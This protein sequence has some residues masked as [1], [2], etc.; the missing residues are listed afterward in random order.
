MIGISVRGAAAGRVFPEG[1]RLVGLSL[2]LPNTCGDALRVHVP[3]LT[4][5]LVHVMVELALARTVDGLAEMLVVPTLVWS[6]VKSIQPKRLLSHAKPRRHVPGALLQ[7]E[8][9]TEVGV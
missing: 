2:P 5:A 9:E 3:G 7:S 8:E 1:T 4:L 6:G